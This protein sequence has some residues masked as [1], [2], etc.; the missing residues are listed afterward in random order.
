MLNYYKIKC[1][2]VS[3][4]SIKIELLKNNPK[5]GLIIMDEWKVGLLIISYFFFKF[6]IN[7]CNTLYNIM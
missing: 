3:K 5:V 2:D 7:S 1:Y 4:L 6:I